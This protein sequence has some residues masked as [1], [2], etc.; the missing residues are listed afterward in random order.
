MFNSFQKYLDMDGPDLSTHDT[1]DQI[2]TSRTKEES[3]TT[4]GQLKTITKPTT[5]YKTLES[6]L[7]DRYLQINYEIQTTEVKSTKNST[8]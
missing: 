8:K 4:T 5:G 1:Y 7:D 3:Y 6:G 2:L